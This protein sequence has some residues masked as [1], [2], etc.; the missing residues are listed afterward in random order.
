M[1]QQTLGDWNLPK[2]KRGSEKYRDATLHW[3]VTW[4]GDIE[5]A[6]FHPDK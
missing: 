2:K 6:E 1:D 5:Q 4:A 3:D